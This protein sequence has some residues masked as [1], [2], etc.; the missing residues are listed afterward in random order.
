[1]NSKKQ[2]TKVSKIYIEA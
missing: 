1:M 2:T